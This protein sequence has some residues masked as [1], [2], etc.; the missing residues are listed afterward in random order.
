ML[1]DECRG[2]D[3]SHRHRG[4]GKIQ[5]GDP[6][7]VTVTTAGNGKV[8]I[9]SGPLLFPIYGCKWIVIA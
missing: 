6:K 1:S 5:V 9:I 8:A 2:L 3:G 4:M 7:R